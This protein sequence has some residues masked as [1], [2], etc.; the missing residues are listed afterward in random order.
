MNVPANS[1]KIS[2]NNIGMTAKGHGTTLAPESLGDVVRFSEAMARGGIALPKHLR[3]EPGA[4]MAVTMQ[5]MQWEMNPFAVAQ[6][7]YSVNGVIAY[8]AQLI[9]S[10]VN[11]RSGIK[12]RLKYAYDGDGNDLTCTVTGILDGEE[13]VYTTPPL[14]QIS[15]KNSPLWKSDP[16]QQLAYYGGRAW[17]RRFC[18]EVILGVYDR[19]EAEQFRGPDNAKDV[20]PARS[21]MADRYS[22]P[23]QKETDETS[24]AETVPDAENET[25]LSDQQ[26]DQAEETDDGVEEAEETSLGFDPDQIEKKQRKLLLGFSEKLFASV[27]GQEHGQTLEEIQQNGSVI[28]DEFKQTVDEGEMAVAASVIWDAFC[29]VCKG[30]ASA[31]DQHSRFAEALSE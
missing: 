1:E 12:G 3:D 21:H 2:I 26:P 7:S 30:T 31:E 22:K 4:C 23:V 28:K 16:R 20:T 8:E 9:T 24:D 6:K 29:A 18:P 25:N 17:A 15:P 14:G 19:D 27:E 11:T 5:A 13:C 10:V